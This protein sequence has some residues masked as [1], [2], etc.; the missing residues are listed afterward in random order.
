M[1]IVILLLVIILLIPIIY[2]F[3]LTAN[4]NPLSNA[5]VEQLAL[6]QRFN[7][8]FHYFNFTIQQFIINKD[9]KVRLNSKGQ[10]YNLNEELKNIPS[11]ASA[12]LKGKKHEWVLF[13]FSKGKNVYLIYTNKGY[14]NQSVSSNISFDV[15]STIAKDEGADT[16]LH[17]HNHPN[18]VL[19]ASQQDILS[20][21]Y[22][23]KLFTKEKINY[24]AFVCGR[25]NY[26]QY[27]W[28]IID[29][30]C[31]L[32]NYINSINRNNGK[33]RSANF[34]LRKE[35]K[36]KKY[37]MKVRL[38]NNSSHNFSIE[39]EEL[40]FNKAQFVNNLN[41][42]K[43]MNHLE[44][45][46]N[47]FIT[48][49][50]SYPLQNYLSVEEVESQ[51]DGKKVIWKKYSYKLS[52]KEFGLFEDLEFIDHSIEHKTFIFKTREFDLDVAKTIVNDFFRIFGYDKNNQG[53]FDDSDK[54]I[55]ELGFAWPGRMWFDEKSYFVSISYYGAGDEFSLCVKW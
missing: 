35:L 26:Y 9:F 42:N 54:R 6:S 50:K 48:N 41:E 31:P 3:Y 34:N 52:K 55:I 22:Y 46:N 39:N 11:I 4:S 28:W 12:I 36:K 16:I 19:Q 1:N 45:V 8:V 25:G 7:D 20:A 30:F 53:K 10:F 24:L 49:L 13:A 23:G 37:F 33:S 15:L 40:F 29:S 27:A 18:G 17:F 32:N 5:E 38:N 2:L 44:Y 21:D 47:L 51:D 43:K 14:D